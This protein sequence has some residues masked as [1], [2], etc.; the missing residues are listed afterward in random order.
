MKYEKVTELFIN[1]KRQGSSSGEIRNVLHPAD[2][3]LVA[4]FHEGGAADT[5]SAID[6]ARNTFDGTANNVERFWNKLPRFWSATKNYSPKLNQK[7]LQN[8]L[9][10][11]ATTLMM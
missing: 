5:V 10:K 3:H 6:A 2:G 4:T 1:G 8:E 11:P 9:L 7:T